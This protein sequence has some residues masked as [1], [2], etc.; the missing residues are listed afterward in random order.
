MSIKVETLLKKVTSMSN[1]DNS[2]IIMDFY[3]YMKGKGSSE[4]H[5]MNNLKV[6]IEYS[7]Y[8]K[9]TG[10]YKVNTK[11]QIILFL[12]TK[13]KNESI[14]PEIRCLIQRYIQ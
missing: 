7:N 1:K 8:I 13:I 3:S 9:E 6:V 2:S 4:N 5:I 12:N 14:D 10:L 11:P